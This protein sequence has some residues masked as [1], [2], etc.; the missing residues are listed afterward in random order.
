MPMFAK[1]PWPCPFVLPNFPPYIE[2]ELE[3]RCYVPR[4][5]R[6]QVIRILY[7]HILQFAELVFHFQVMF[8]LA[9]TVVYVVGESTLMN[10]T[11]FNT[12]NCGGVNQVQYE[13]S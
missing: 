6:L 7:D 2:S 5:I 12:A 8:K 10:E 11:F 9:K 1:R 3:K 4:K 13:K